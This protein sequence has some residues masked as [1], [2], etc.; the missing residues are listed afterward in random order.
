[1]MAELS[2]MEQLLAFCDFERKHNTPEGKSHIAE[3]AYLEIERLN[4]KKAE[5]ESDNAKSLA[6]SCEWLSKLNEV[7][8]QRDTLKAALIKAKSCIETDRTALADCHMNPDTNEVDEEGAAGL[9]EYD[10]VLSTIKDALA[11]VPRVPPAGHVLTITGWQLGEAIG[12]V[13][14]DGE[15]EQ[16]EQA[17]CIAHS[18]TVRDDDGKLY[19]P[20]LFVWLEEYPDEGCIPLTGK[21]TP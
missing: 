11:G 12:F 17:V 20:G 14:P 21:P 13:A 18:D 5:L 15:D 4:K 10:D 6:L 2:R 3:W 7:L 9:A 1:M 8:N 16:M 19:Q